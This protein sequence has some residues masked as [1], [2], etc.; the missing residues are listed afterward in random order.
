MDEF[1][2]I[3][4]WILVIYLAV[5]ASIVWFSNSTTFV[6]AGWGIGGITSDDR[7]TESDLN[8]YNVNIFGTDCSQVSANDLVNTTACGISQ[9]YNGGAKLINSFWNF[10]TAWS[11]L[12]DAI[13]TPLGT[14]GDLFKGILIPFLGL[15][16]FVAIL[17]VTLRIVGVIRGGS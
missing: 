12:L 9:I 11:K 16:E 2:S 15:I 13:F 6:D 1:T 4:I 5:N 10:L 3:A 17:V 8:S 7:F 14:L